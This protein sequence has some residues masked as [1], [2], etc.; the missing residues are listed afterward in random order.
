MAIQLH[1][2]ECETRTIGPLVL[3]TPGL[4][5]LGLR[6]IVNR[7]GPI[8]EQAELDHGLVAALTTQSRR[9]DPTA[10]YDLPGWAARCA[11]STLSPEIERTGQ[12]N[13]DRAGRLL[14]ALYDQRAVIWG[15]LV[16]KAAR[17]SGRDLPRLHADTMAMTFAGLWA[18]PPTD[19]GGPRLEPG[20]NPAG[21]W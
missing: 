2:V 10:L 14:D 1:E 20:D 16:A 4:R 17:D 21:E 15:D 5:R 6:E 8:A 19:A 3:T 9:S 18:D 7:H 13:D 11:M 12:V